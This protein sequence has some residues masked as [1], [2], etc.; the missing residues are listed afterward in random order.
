MNANRVAAD[1]VSK[2][3]QKEG[4]GGGAAPAV[5]AKP[6]IESSVRFLKTQRM[7]KTVPIK[8]TTVPDSP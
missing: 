5:P 3:L 4:Q 2:W 7:K 6:R 8:K 1:F